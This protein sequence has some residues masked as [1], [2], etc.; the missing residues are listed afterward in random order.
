[1]FRTRSVNDLVDEAV[2]NIADNSSL[3]ATQP[4]SKARAIVAA[5]ARLVG[6]L[7][8][9][10]STQT[11]SLTLPQLSG[12]ALDLFAETFGIYRR[13]AEKARAEIEDR[14]FKYYVKGGTFG[15]LNNGQ[16]I[17]VPA[18]TT[19]H[20]SDSSASAYFVQRNTLVLSAADNFTYFAADQSGSDG[21]TTYPAASF[22]SHDFV[23]Y[24]DSAYGSLLVTN[25]RG[26]SGRDDESD[27]NLRFRVKNAMLCSAGSNQTAVRLAALGVA[28]VSDI[29]IVSDS[30]AAGTFDVVVFGTT[31]TVSDALVS[32]VQQAIGDVLAIGVTANVV[33][34]RLVGLSLR[35]RLTFRAGIDAGT[36]TAL[37]V[38]A[39]QAVLDYVTTLSPGKTVSTTDLA[40]IVLGYATDI[41]GIGSASRPFDEALIWQPR[42]SGSRIPG[43][44]EGS[45]LIGY[46]EEMVLEPYM[47][48][49]VEF[50]EA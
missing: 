6:T 11:S 22:T 48:V 2:S 40:G 10:I 41:V 15:D 49:P 4:G 37:L 18:G 34:S 23:G 25:D 36:K 45:Y 13:P 7:S 35:G 39:R 38:G 31:P 8:S 9:D 47:A 43:R 20:T 27:A 16:S 28:G 19:I 17:V 3:A 12:Q 24:A 33:P 26:I 32:K 5:L 21:T 44:L 1:M 42:S 14:V 50:T 46:D 29:R 30:G